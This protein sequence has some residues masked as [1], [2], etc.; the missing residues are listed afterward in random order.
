MHGH[1]EVISRQVLLRYGLAGI[2]TQ[3]S[4]EPIPRIMNDHLHIDWAIQ[5]FSVGRR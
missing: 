5:D 1:K 4:Q 3:A 2:R